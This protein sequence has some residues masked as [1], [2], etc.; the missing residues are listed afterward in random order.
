MMERT[1]ET[2]APSAFAR[3]EG[4]F[5]VTNPDGR[6]YTVRVRTQKVEADFAPGQK[7]VAVMTGRDNEHSYTGV[8]FLR[9][10]GLRPW[11]RAEGT[12]LARVAAFICRVLLGA[13]AL[14]PGYSIQE[15]RACIRCGRKLTTPES[16]A[17]GLG[18]ECASRR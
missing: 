1:A 17:L 15:S 4:T 11:R 7:V 18:P 10:E 8:G 6:H 16:L 13:Q 2:L 14:P 5:T 12:I 3:I 9:P